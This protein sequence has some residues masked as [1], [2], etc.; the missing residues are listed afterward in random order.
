MIIPA[1]ATYEEVVDSLVDV[2]RVANAVEEAAGDGWDWDDLFVIASQQSTIREVIRDW[3]VFFDEFKKL[4]PDTALAALSEARTKIGAMGKVATTAFAFL[5]EV[6]RTYKFIEQ[7]AVAGIERY[8]SWR[9]LL[10][11]AEQNQ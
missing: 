4:T 3:P 9:T 1:N 6:A 7:T 8:N 2:F 11:P 10:K 5:D